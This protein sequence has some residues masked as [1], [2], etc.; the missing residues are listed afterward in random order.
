MGD[1]RHVQHDGREHITAGSQM[2]RQIKGI[3]KVMLDIPFGRT[4]PDKDPV[5]KKQVTAVGREIDMQTDCSRVRHVESA[6][7]IAHL[8]M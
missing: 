1:A 8:I 3:E 2:G 7:K 6:A 4:T 5:A